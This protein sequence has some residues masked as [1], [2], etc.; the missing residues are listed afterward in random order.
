M[1]ATESIVQE[2]RPGHWFKPGVSANPGGR[3]KGSR[4]ASSLLRDALKAVEK[5]RA[6]SAPKTP[7][8]CTIRGYPSC[9]TLNQHFTNQA[10]LD[11]AVMIAYERKLVPD[12][13]HETG[14]RQPVNINVIYAGHGAVQVRQPLVPAEAT[15]GH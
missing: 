9:A 3:S 7:C 2:Q 5:Q 10:F 6:K 15:D 1:V 8:R 11:N 14:E 4:N 13:T 12:L